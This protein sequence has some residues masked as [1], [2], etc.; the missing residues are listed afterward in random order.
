LAD[1]N[2][3]HTTPLLLFSIIT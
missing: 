3:A 1:A 2:I